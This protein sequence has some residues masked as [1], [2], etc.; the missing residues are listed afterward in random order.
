[1][2][3]ETLANSSRSLF[4]SLAVTAFASGL[5]PQSAVAQQMEVIDEIS[6]YAADEP[7]PTFDDPKA[8]IDAFEGTLKTSD[9]SPLAKLLGLDAD[10]VRSDKNANETFEKI[11]EGVTQKLVLEETPDRVILDIGNELWPF[12]FPIVKT[13]DGKWSFDTIAGLEEIVNRRIGENELQAIATAR[14]YVDAQRD[15][16]SV[17]R[18]GDGVLEYAQK[19]ISSEGDTDGLYWPYSPE[20]G[21][22][23]AGGFVDEARLDEARKGD[24]YFGYRFSILSNQGDNIAGG[25]YEYVIN[26]NMIGG[27]ALI[28][29]PAN[30]A[31]SGV[32]TFVVNQAGTVYEKDLGEATV[33]IV[34]YITSF[35]PDDSWDVSGD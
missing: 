35:N 5:G 10:R 3:L 19:L 33:E 1:M 24:G 25:A 27:F 32:K 22:S 9:T 28:A 13:D 26:G 2:M 34:P 6:D 18:D 4:L 30:Y 15:Y 12:P 8:L 31:I 7:P 17:D 16:A 23:P 29:W 20:A 11:R 14:E 21:E